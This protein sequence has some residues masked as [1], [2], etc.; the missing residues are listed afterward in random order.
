MFIAALYFT[1]WVEYSC[2]KEKGMARPPNV[3]HFKCSVGNIRWKANRFFKI[4]GTWK[5]T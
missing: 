3:L 4:E 1:I 2:A 5:M